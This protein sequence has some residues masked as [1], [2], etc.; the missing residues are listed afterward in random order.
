[1][2]G[3]F[4]FCLGQDF[5]LV[6]SFRSKTMS[7]APAESCTAPSI[8][9]YPKTPGHTSKK[10][11]DALEEKKTLNDA[12]SH[13]ANALTL[14]LCM[15]TTNHCTMTTS[16]RCAVD[17]STSYNALSRKHNFPQNADGLSH[18]ASLL[19][20]LLSRCR[21]VIRVFTSLPQH[22]IA[23]K[24]HRNLTACSFF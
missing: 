21:A 4:W 2:G 19:L 24:I 12:P 23:L 5:G 8:H 16:R 13:H 22:V 10:F 1:M 7:S 3:V 14:Q 11:H 18:N 15:H 9:V 6:C 17:N 20:G